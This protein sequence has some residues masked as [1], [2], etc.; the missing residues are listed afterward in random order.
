M[1][2][3]RT[4]SPQLFIGAAKIDNVT[5]PSYQK[6]A[7]NSEYNGVLIKSMVNRFSPSPVESVLKEQMK[8]FL[9]HSNALSYT[10][11]RMASP[12]KPKQINLSKNNNSNV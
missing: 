3:I 10:T 1:R 2:N 8:I 12:G 11:T 4:L 7:S 5:I 6:Q 9:N